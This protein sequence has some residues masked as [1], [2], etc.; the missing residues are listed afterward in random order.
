MVR[1]KGVTAPHFLAL[2]AL[3]PFFVQTKMTYL[4][5]TSMMYIKRGGGRGGRKVK[6]NS[7]KKF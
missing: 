7:G 6:E 5:F 3:S 2:D 1:W 4:V